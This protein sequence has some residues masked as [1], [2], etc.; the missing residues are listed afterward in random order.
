MGETQNRP[1]E[2]FRKILKSP[3]W[4]VF[5]VFKAAEENDFAKRSAK[6][7]AIRDFSA[8]G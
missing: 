2:Y 8:R 5:S 4:A 6:V 7:A 3:V 1:R